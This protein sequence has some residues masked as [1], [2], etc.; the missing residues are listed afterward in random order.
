MKSFAS[1]LCF[2]A[3]VSISHGTNDSR[4]ERKNDTCD[5]VFYSQYDQNSV[6]QT[7]LN[8]TKSNLISV[9]P[10]FQIKNDDLYESG[11]S[12]QQRNN[13]KNEER[14]KTIVYMK[15]IYR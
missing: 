7:D 10:N 4:C 13:E 1:I 15:Q 5:G 14:N 6:N 3:I 8:E 11:T 9:Q 2:L 12:A